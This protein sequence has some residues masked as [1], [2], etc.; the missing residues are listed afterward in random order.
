M[1]CRI[2]QCAPLRA[3]WK[4][5]CEWLA[6]AKQTSAP[7][8]AGDALNDSQILQEIQDSVSSIR[9]CW[10]MLQRDGG[11]QVVVLHAPDS[12][13]Q[14]PLVEVAGKYGGSMESSTS[15]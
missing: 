10:P 2:R 4:T 13:L 1:Q 6:E 5:H 11:E 15:D 12:L 3:V 9:Q 14:Q 8:G 7:V